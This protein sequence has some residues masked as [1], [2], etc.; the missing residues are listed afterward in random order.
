VAGYLRSHAVQPS[1]LVAEITETVVMTDPDRTHRVVQDLSELGIRIAIDDFGTGYSSLSRLTSLPVDVLKL[2]RP[3]IAGVPDD[4]Q[5][6]KMA[7]AVIRLALS[8]GMEPL[9]EGVETEEQRRFLA[10]Q[11]CSLAQGF[12]WSPPV[13]PEELVRWLGVRPSAPSPLA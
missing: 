11:G 6:R 12:L 7:I 4:P 2:D 8:L 1:S 9:A 10:E 13:S 5:A 3:F